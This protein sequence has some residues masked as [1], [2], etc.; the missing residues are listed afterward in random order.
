VR[1][2]STTEGA[3]STDPTAGISYRIR[4][5][6]DEAGSAQQ[7]A[8]RAG[9]APSAILQYL[10][11]ESGRIS[12]PSIVALVKLAQTT[13]VSLTWLLT[14]QGPKLQF[15]E[16]SPVDEARLATA[17]RETEEI[18]VAVKRTMTAEKKAHVV[19]AIYEL[20]QGDRKPDRQKVVNLFKA[21]AA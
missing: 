6:V 3:R 15:P 4:D 7:L 17:I 14:G 5:L 1:K 16:L 2:S 13:Q 21:V 18:L 12:K 8:E 10:P 11:R 19:V 20:Y 9:L